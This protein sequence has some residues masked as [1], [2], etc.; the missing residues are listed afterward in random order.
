MMKETADLLKKYG[1]SL[2]EN[3][4]LSPMR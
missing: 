4:I 3:G 2:P 1:F